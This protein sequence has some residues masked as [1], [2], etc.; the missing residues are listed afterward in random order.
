MTQ[1]LLLPSGAE[2]T[3][4]ALRRDDSALRTLLRR[5]RV[6]ERARPRPVPPDDP[7]SPIRCL[8]DPRDIYLA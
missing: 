2:S 5:I 6:G 3:P 1:L 7:R 4:P 8:I